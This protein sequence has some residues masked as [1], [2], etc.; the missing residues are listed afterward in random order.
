MNARVAAMLPVTMGACGTNSADNTVQPA[1]IPSQVLP[2]APP[3]QPMPD[4]D[5][6]CPADVKPCTD[7]SFVSCSPTKGCAFDTCP[8]ASTP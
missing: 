7:G 2:T 8:G 1:S 6:A 5:G 3:P 4:E